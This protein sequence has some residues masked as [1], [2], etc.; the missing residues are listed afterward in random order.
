[1]IDIHTPP[2]GL[3]LHPAYRLSIISP[4]PLNSR[5]FTPS[6]GSGFALLGTPTWL[7]LLCKPLRAAANCQLVSILF[8]PWHTHNGFE[9]CD[10]K[11][12]ILVDADVHIGHPDFVKARRQIVQRKRTSLVNL[13]SSNP[14]LE[15]VFD[16]G[17]MPLVSSTPSN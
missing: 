8:D 13:V 6:R 16:Q 12:V 15:M 5:F 9:I 17:K 10:Q 1:M 2:P 4:L 3:V 11:S 14:V 7:P